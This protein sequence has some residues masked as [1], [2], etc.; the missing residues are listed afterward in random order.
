MRKPHEQRRCP[1]CNRLVVT[2]I[3][4]RA[5]CYLARATEHHIREHYV[6]DDCSQM[7]LKVG[8]PIPPMPRSEQ[9]VHYRAI[10]KAFRSVAQPDPSAKR[11]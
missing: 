8:K 5:G 7:G 3:L 9:L 10:V 4:Q 11:E 1:F 6:C 2:L